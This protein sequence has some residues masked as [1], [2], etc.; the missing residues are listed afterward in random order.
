MSARTVSPQEASRLIEAGATLIDIR[1]AD[2][3]AREAIPGA[4]H[5]P[6]EQLAG[7]TLPANEGAIIIYHCRSGNRTRMNAGQLA[8][9]AICETYIL[10]GGL[11]AWKR[12][13]LPVRVDRSQPMEL[14]RQVQISAGSLIL[15]G[16][17]LGAAVSPWF[18]LVSGFVGAGLVFAGV[19]GF[20]GLA[21]VLMRMPWNRR[22]QPQ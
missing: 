22:A 14:S 11:D 13:G 18:Y 20:C 2:E 15:L 3:H 6:M 7:A 4:R 17:I 5:V 21:R 12:A 10:E 1:S 19:S 8:E 9:A 16:V